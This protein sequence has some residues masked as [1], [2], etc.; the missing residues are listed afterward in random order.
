M[1]RSADYLVA[2]SLIT[3]LPTMTF[4]AGLDD[5][6]FYSQGCKLLG[7]F[8][9]ALGETPRPTAILLH[10]VPGVEQNLDIAYA[11]RDAGW[12]CLY[13]H[14]R[15]SWGSQGDY[16]FSNLADDVQT[17]AEWLLEQDCVNSRRLALIGGSIGGYA[18][19][20]AGAREPRFKTL[21]VI[22][23]L[24][25]PAT[26][27]LAQTIFDG[28]A[29][30]LHSVTGEALREQW[31]DLPPVELM[32]EG[33]V[34]RDILL[35]SGDRDELFPPAHYTAL[36]ESLPGIIWHRLAEGDHGFSLCRG[37]LVKIVVGWLQERN[38]RQ[39]RHLK[40]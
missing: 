15:G 33:L 39:V 22:C 18:A 17:A 24:V 6:V 2:R 25:D 12:N 7:G 16:E 38:L 8:Y 30:M 21:V 32:A 34:D 40:M 10:G 28:W 23:P 11:L 36:V 1:S 3:Y 26:T 27:D 20:V 14:Y 37:E 9:R 31:Y 29:E 19:F 13:F 35:V 4:D 5:V